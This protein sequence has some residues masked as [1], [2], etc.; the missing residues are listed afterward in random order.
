MLNYSQMQLKNS[1]NDLALTTES[2]WLIAFTTNETVLLT[3]SAMFF[4]GGVTVHLAHEVS[5]EC[6]TIGVGFYTTV[7][8]G[9]VSRK[10]NVVSDYSAYHFN[11]ILAVPFMW[12][13]Q[14]SF[15]VKM[16]VP[17]SL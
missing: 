14:W 1:E 9:E 3:H 8:E 11:E 17:Y 16:C 2:W 12:E 4:E 15:I 13:E 7:F 5:P 10:T 6:V